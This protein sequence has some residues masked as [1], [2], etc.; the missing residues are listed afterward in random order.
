MATVNVR[1]DDYTHAE[2]Q[3]VARGRGITVSDLLREAIDVTLGR[4]A[5]QTTVGDAPSSLTLVQRRTLALQHEILTRLDP[6]GADYHQRSIEVLEHGFVTEYDREFYAFSPELSPAE[7]RLV[8]D[9]LEMFRV[10][11]ASMSGVGPDAV[12]QIGD[13]A[14]HGLTYLG[15]DHNNTYEGR[16]SSYAHF[17]IKE[18]RWLEL[19]DRF[20]SN[21]EHGNSH[22]PMLA[23]YEGM[24][25]AFKPIWNERLSNNKLGYGDDRYRLTLDELKQVYEA[26]SAR[27]G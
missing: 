4:D 14:E 17:L 23:T 25:A 20:D 16:L 15:F 13:Y 26:R 22:M 7:T 19:A 3:A 27:R 11:K 8:V 2:L 12:K 21:H 24:L 6:D 5:G 10:L 1:T 18:G 9:V